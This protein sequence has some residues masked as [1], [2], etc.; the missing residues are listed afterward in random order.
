MQDTG[1]QHI[2]KWMDILRHTRHPGIG[3]YEWCNSFS[4][5]IRSFLRISQ[6]DDL[7]AVEQHRV[8]KCITAQI[9]DFEQAILAQVNKKWKPTTLTDGAFDLDELKKDISSADSKFSVRKRKYKPTALI[10]ECLVSRAS[11]QGIPALSFAT[12][13]PVSGKA[14]RGADDNG[15]RSLKRF[16]GGRQRQQYTMEQDLWN[17]D[18][19]CMQDGADW[20]ED[21]AHE[22]EATADWDFYAFQQ[23]SSSLPPC[24]SK[25]RSHAHNGEVLQIE[26]KRSVTQR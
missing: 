5:L 15:K 11:Q 8:N 17:D 22:E 7:N 23:S 16:Q 1:D 18:D 4:P 25:H 21:H 14:K 2:I 6:M 9:T 13:K 20:D 3:I 12:V 26:R 19:E 24:T 10:L